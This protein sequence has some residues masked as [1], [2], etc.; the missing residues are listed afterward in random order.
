MVDFS[1]IR[2]PNFNKDAVKMGQAI[3]LMELQIAEWVEE[4]IRYGFTQEREDAIYQYRRKVIVFKKSVEEAEERYFEEREES[5]RR[6]EARRA[7]SYSRGD[8]SARDNRSKLHQ[9]HTQRNYGDSL[10]S[11]DE[12][13]REN[14]YQSYRPPPQRQQRL[15]SR[16]RSRS[17]SPMRSSYRHESPENSR[18]NASHQQTAQVRM[19]AGKNNVTKTKKWR[20]GQ[21]ALSEIRKYQNSTDLLIQ[22]APFRRLVH[23]IIQEATGFDSG[24]RIRADAMSALQEA[25]EAFIVEMF[26][27]SVL[28]SNH[29]KRVTLMTADI[30]LYRRLCLRN[31]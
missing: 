27:G 1:L 6:E 11:D 24:F 17:S 20:P 9:S 25:A 7:M 12:N 31:L 4:Q 5:R 16:S 18:R 21:K 26:E 29:A 3:D 10:D 19:R 28:I 30:Q 13:E 8:I 23:Q 22:K 14:G 2:T 15:R